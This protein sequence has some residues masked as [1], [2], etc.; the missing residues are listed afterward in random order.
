M[1]NIP[2]DISH[3]RKSQFFLRLYC[4]EQCIASAFHSFT[5]EYIAKVKQRHHHRNI[6]GL[7]SEL[8]PMVLLTL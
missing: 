1:C 4:H 8:D 5:V 6:A 2:S 7:N 3:T